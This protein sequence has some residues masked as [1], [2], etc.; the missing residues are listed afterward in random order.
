MTAQLLAEC[1]RDGAVG[2]ASLGAVGR[3]GEREP[4][5]GPR[6]EVIRGDQHPGP[7]LDRLDEGGHAAPR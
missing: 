2:V 5:A 7:R 6:R 4:D 3:A 1:R